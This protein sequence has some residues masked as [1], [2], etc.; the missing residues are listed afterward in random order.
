MILFYLQPWKEKEDLKTPAEVRYYYLSILCTYTVNTTK[1]QYCSDKW[2]NGI[3]F[4]SSNQKQSSGGRS[5]SHWATIYFF[6]SK[7]FYF[8]S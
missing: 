5:S 4:C 8:K 2:E 7:D 6:S 3:Q 1:A